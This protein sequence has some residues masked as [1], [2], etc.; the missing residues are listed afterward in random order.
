[1]ERKARYNI[2]SF[3]LLDKKKKENYMSVL[4]GEIADADSKKEVE[5]MPKIMDYKGLC[6]TCNN[7]SVCVY[8]RDTGRQVLEC[9]EFSSINAAPPLN[10]AAILLSQSTGSRVRID[11]KKEIYKS[12]GLCRNCEQKGDCTYPK[13]EGGVWHCEEYK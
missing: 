10:T 5:Y 4:M 3:Y 9:E 1:M 6:P 2:K 8:P 13:L 11:S 12:N 7:N